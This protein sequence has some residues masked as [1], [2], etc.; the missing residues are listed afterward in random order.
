[1]SVLSALSAP[2][3]PCVSV[4]ALDDDNICIG[5]QR[6]GEEI[7]RWGRMSADEKRAVLE[8]CHERTQARGQYLASPSAS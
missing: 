7:S 3:S 4:C 6:S 5:C 1:M 8:R 2:K